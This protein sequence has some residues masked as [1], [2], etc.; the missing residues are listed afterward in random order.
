MRDSRPVLL[1]FQDK[2]SRGRRYKVSVQFLRFVEEK[3]FFLRRF[4][5]EREIDQQASLEI[6]FVGTG[7]ALPETCFNGPR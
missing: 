3:R 2:S 7:Q 1:P 4:D 6:W 5:K